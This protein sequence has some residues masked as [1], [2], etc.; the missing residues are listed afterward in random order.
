M[1][2]VAATFSEEFVRHYRGFAALRNS[3]PPTGPREPPRVILH[4]GPTGSGKSFLARAA[5]DGITPLE[6]G[7][8]YY[9]V[10]PPS[11]SGGIWFD[12]YDGQSR[13][14][15]DDFNGATSHIRL[16]YLLQLLD[17]YPMSVPIKGGFVKWRPTTIIIT[18]NLHPSEWYDYSGKHKEHYPALKRRFAEV[19][20]FQR[21]DDPPPFP[22]KSLQPG[23]GGPLASGP[24]LTEWDRFWRGYSY[25]ET[26]NVMPF[27]SRTITEDQYDFMF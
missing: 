3:L 20:C 4:Y 14:I 10:S 23:R 24:V 16:D 17:K 25:D 7:V 6:S 2:E 12:G 18:T 22:H 8:D 21:S 9:V 13:V 26:L 19:L 5:P 1:A 11:G 27:T 15:F